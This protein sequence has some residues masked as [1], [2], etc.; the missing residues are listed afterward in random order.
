MLHVLLIL[1]KS[2]SVEKEEK[3][4]HNFQNEKHDCVYFF[5]LDFFCGSSPKNIITRNLD[6]LMRVVWVPISQFQV[7]NYNPEKSSECNHEFH[8]FLK[9]ENR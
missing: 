4:E 2:F 8:F 6:V 1:Y 9:K 7:V 3:Q 5:V